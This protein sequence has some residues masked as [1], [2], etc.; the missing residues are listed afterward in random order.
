MN[1]SGRAVLPIKSMD[2]G[3]LVIYSGT[4]SKV[5]F[6]GVRI[7]WI[8]AEKACI[9]RMVCI[10]RYSEIAPSMILQAAICDF[11]RNGY[12]DQHA[13]RMHRTFRKRM[14][15]AVR[16]LRQH[17]SRE[18]ADWKEPSGGFLIWLRLRRAASPRFEW[19]G[20]FP[21]HNVRVALGRYFFASAP[22][23]TFL[24]LSISALNEDKITE[25]IQR[26]SK[27]RRSE[28]QSAILGLFQGRYCEMHV[29]IE[30]LLRYTAEERSKRCHWFSAQGGAA[31]TIPPAGEVIPDSGA[32]RVG[33]NRAELSWENW[34]RPP[35]SID[36]LTQS[37]GASPVY[38]P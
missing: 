1:Y 35:I 19:T 21:W 29:T 38:G 13:S 36:R 26:L 14:Q 18:W 22:S 9:E 5:L 33:C 16:A 24:R 7:G 37:R 30:E 32:L 17:L 20:S 34:G 28:R 27:A 12:Y 10:R 31:L 6:P 8:V 11:C 23:D 25:G 4:F 2:K 3:R 15:T